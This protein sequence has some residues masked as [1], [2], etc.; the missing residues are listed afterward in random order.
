MTKTKTAFLNPRIV[1][2]KVDRFEPKSAWKRTAVQSVKG[3]TRIEIETGETYP[4]GAPVTIAAEDTLEG[5][6]VK[7]FVKGFES[8]MRIVRDAGRAERKASKVAARA[9]ET[10]TCPSC[11]GAYVA[12]VAGTP[13][14]EDVPASGSRMVLHGFKRPGWGHTVGS[15]FGVGYEPFE[16][17]CL[18]TKHTA[19]HVAKQLAHVKS[20]RKSLAAGKVTS[21]RIEVYA[22]NGQ[23]K[24]ERIAPGHDKWD[25]ALASEI[26]NADSSIR[27]MTRD[28]ADLKAKIR[29][30][31]P[32]AK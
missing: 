1:S 25:R 28:L 5:Q 18:G 7:R 14:H 20:Y 16:V 15:C 24:P 29:S 21:L 17:S 13:A 12:K 8:L 30:W 11:F 19:D 2:H 9:A 32:A 22:G 10:S 31:K 26:A 4:S 27:A 3:R 6:C 23:Y